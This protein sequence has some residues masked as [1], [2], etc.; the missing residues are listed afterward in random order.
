MTKDPDVAASFFEDLFGWKS[1]RVAE[2]YA[3]FSMGDLLVGGMQTI[4]PEQRTPPSWMPYF[5]V[6]DADV[7]ASR[8]AELGGGVLVP[9]TAV[10]SG[11]FLIIQDAQRAVSGLIEMGPEGAARGVDGS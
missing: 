4:Q 3:S 10:P 1:D 11:R 8:V 5:V 7:A 6:P 2:I 9:P